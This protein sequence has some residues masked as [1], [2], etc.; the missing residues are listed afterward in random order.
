MGRPGG[1]RN[2]DHEARRAEILQRLAQRLAMRDAMHAS[3]RELAAAAGVSISTLQHYFGRRADIVAA[4]LQDAE[5]HAAEH[6][7]QVREPAGS[8]R[9]SVGAALAYIRLGFERFGVGDIHALGLVE[10]VRNGAVGPI[11]VDSVLEP[12]IDALAARLAAHQLRGEM[13]ASVEPRHAALMLLAP[14][15]FIMLHQHELGGAARHPADM[16]RFFDDHL[17]AFVKA[18]RLGTGTVD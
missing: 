6:F 18:H 10:G 13:Q 1:T 16:D 14:V 15:V 3:Y 9:E 4:I 7:E 17:N 11:F 12:S 2:H 8:F 5:N